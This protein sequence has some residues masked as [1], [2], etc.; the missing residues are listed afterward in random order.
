[1]SNRSTSHSSKKSMGIYNI[2]LLKRSVTLTI[3][4]VGNNLFQLLENKI[5]ISYEGKC[6]I[7][8][9]IK[10][11]SIRLIS[12]SSGLIEEDYIKFDTV[13]ECLICCPVEGMIINN[14]VVKNKTKAGLRC[15]IND[16][17]EVPVIIFIARDHHYK[18]ANFS[19]LE[20]NDIVSIKVIGIRFELNDENISIIANLN[21]KKK[22][23]MVLSK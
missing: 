14:C 15:Q 3:S 4:E 2:N 13:F 9:Y 19:E 11:D 8:G 17:D 18:N 23:K 22:T 20:I 5:K 1:M 10:K 16:D 6:S 7:E 12:H 21:N